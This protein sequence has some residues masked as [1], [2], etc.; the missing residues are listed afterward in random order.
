M[1]I[2][3]K[4]AKKVLVKL[5]KK[6]EKNKTEENIK[7]FDLILRY[8]YCN[9]TLQQQSQEWTSGIENKEISEEIRNME[10][11]NPFYFSLRI[12]GAERTASLPTV[13]A[14]M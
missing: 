4:D 12:N 9:E 10:E 3:I 8:L 1:Y 13:R 5:L 14:V 2:N 7:N 11:F 6:F